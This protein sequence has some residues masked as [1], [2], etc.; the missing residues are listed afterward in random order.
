[1]AIYPITTV[2]AGD[3]LTAGTPSISNKAHKIEQKELVL[4]SLPQPIV[5]SVGVGSAKIGLNPSFTKDHQDTTSKSVRFTFGGAT[6]QPNIGAGNQSN[7]GHPKL[8]YGAKGINPYGIGM[9]S[10]PI[11]P[12]VFHSSSHS[13]DINFTQANPESNA[14]NIAFH[15]GSALVSG[16]A[17]GATDSY[18]YAKVVTAFVI[19]PTG[20]NGEG[21]GNGLLR[22]SSRPLLDTNLIGNGL[23]FG[24]RF[25]FGGASPV[26]QVGAINATTIG[27]AI[28][29]KGAD[30]IKPPSINQFKTGLA[31]TYSNKL[32]DIGENNGYLNLDFS[33]NIVIQNSLNVG[34]YFWDGYRLTTSGRQSSKFGTLAI[35]T[36]Q[37]Y[38]APV[39]VNAFEYGDTHISNKDIGLQP[40]GIASTS[41]PASP[42]IMNWARKIIA[43][44]IR[45]GVAG[46]PKVWH[47]YRIVS[48]E[49]LLSMSIGSG[50]TATHGV[51]EVIGVGKPNDLYGTA[52]IS[53][54]PRFINVSSVIKDTRS[55]HMVGGTQT[56][57]PPGYVAT[58]FGERIIPVGANI[59]PLGLDTEWGLADVGLHTR[60]VGP[61]GYNSFGELAGDRWGHNKIYN[62][63]QYIDQYYQGDS[64]L[65]P[66]KWSDW[67]S[68]ENRNKIIGAV[69]SISQK[70]GYN[71][72]D[73]GATILSPSGITPPV[74]ARNDVSLIAYAIRTI[75]LEGID[76][77]VSESWGVVYN[78]ARVISP[79]GDVQTLMG[80]DAG[81]VSNRRYYN[82]VG[83]I[84]SL[85]AGA[86]AIGY[87]I[88]GVDIEP[89]YS[90][91]P[92][93]IEL[94]TV[95]LYTRYIDLVGLDSEKHGLPDL[96][97]HFNNIAPS[98]SHSNRFGYPILHNVT[99]TLYGAGHDS[100][101]FGDTSI[102]TQWRDLLA[103]GSNTALIGLL[104]ISD[105]KQELEVRGLYAGGFS[106]Q[107]KVIKLG[108]NP[109][110]TQ[111][112]W[113]NN[114]SNNG[115]GDGYGSDELAFG[116]PGINQNV[117]APNSIVNPSPFGS[118][119]VR[120]NTISVDGGYFGN[121]ISS[122][123]SIFNKSNFLSVNGIDAQIAVGKPRLSPHTIWAVV[124]A[125]EQA[126]RNHDTGGLHYV[127]ETR[128]K[129][130]GFVVGRPSVESTI[131][132][133]APY[134]FNALRNGDHDTA[135][136]LQI[137]YP[138]NFRLSRFGIPS[139]PFSLQSIGFREGI[140]ASIEAG[141]PSIGP[142]P[143]N[144]PA[145][146]FSRGIESPGIG[147][148]NIENKTR[149]PGI[150]GFDALR[151]GHSRANDTPYM[152]QSLRI[153]EFV[154]MAISGGVLTEFG[155]AWISL[156]IRD[157][158]AVG[159]DSF[160][161]D[162]N[163]SSFDDRMKVKYGEYRQP[164]PSKKE[165]TP[166]GINSYS[167]GDSAI[168]L[169]QHF[170]RPDG[171]SDQFRKGG[172]HA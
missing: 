92:P 38:I 93:Q 164:T 8:S 34:F 66:P 89:R 161:S 33:R 106:L 59:Y 163:L 96:S 123:L 81:I 15:W 95:F 60:Y 127:G 3:N 140:D 150:S 28:I 135:M 79:I 22:N 124:E 12:I 119:S 57:Q 102:R 86:P 72:V 54:S 153:G 125:P 42:T 78:G 61:R 171:N 146:I 25:N 91:G 52:W 48:P 76:S 50:L 147:R 165:I 46:E 35:S 138:E 172:L 103:Q 44:G 132:T 126:K 17:I 41:Q 58:L 107:H 122:K 145:R 151:M 75:A 80:D 133:L 24:G 6:V 148:L 87:R 108:T 18:G 94:P 71:Q 82:N 2:S 90:I 130:A 11:P 55:N 139:I 30:L 53:H 7:Y 98:W 101:E 144:G 97:I 162:Y 4:E 56:L 49:A 74:S 62:A 14:K 105:T 88:R 99:P 84:D 128:T 13:A 9:L 43:G 40:I 157:I 168:R 166:T 137:I 67:Q 167:S 64:G 39:G 120:T 143:Y 70:F 113:H 31:I 169:N 83:R 160:A 134:G 10:T 118:I 158:Q 170:I 131:R 85:E 20:V 156:K 16:A 116:K 69:G 73:N 1:M 110:V 159:A 51:R 65:V 152:W 100:S 37:S 136:S 21:V 29:T 155:T 68:I 36:L 114:E 129:P 142:P 19:R 115:E 154:P 109:Y 26:T 141:K 77:F 63:V 23:F 5:V 104:K 117:L 112:V 121:S 47:R 111:N 27:N 45:H 149:Y 32:N